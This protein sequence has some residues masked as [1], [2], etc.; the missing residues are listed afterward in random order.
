MNARRYPRTLGEAF[1]QT[2]H[3]ACALTV[4]HESLFSRFRRWMREQFKQGA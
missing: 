3:Y 4:S 1:P 2:T